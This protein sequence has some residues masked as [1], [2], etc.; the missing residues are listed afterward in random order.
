MRQWDKQPSKPQVR[1]TVDRRQILLGS[2]ALLCM[3]ALLIVGLTPRTASAPELPPDAA[4]AGSDAS[5]LL[6]ESCQVI[7]HMTYTP[8][9]HSLTRRQSLPGEL[10]GKTR[11]DLEAA[12][13]LWQITG[14]APGEVTME[15]S[16]AIFCPEHL[17]LM[18]DE[19]GMLCIFQ[20]RYG[21]ALA[22]VKSLDL[23]LSDLPDS[24]QE[25]LRPGKGFP[26]QEDLTL[27]LESLDS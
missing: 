18:P 26:T 23:P 11:A 3:A 2:L 13:D 4:Q 19:S 21:D 8:C 1:A 20:N 16:L 6:L 17:I 9:G 12:Y 7:Q 10:A 22:L 5:L 15:Q 14:F 24:Y 25:E 27:Y